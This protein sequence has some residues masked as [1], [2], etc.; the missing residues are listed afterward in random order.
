[1]TTTWSAPYV[2]LGDPGKITLKSSEDPSFSL[3]NTT[4]GA[5]GLGLV[6]GNEYVTASVGWKIPAGLMRYFVPAVKRECESLRGYVDSCDSSQLSLVVDSS[7]SPPCPPNSQYGCDG[8]TTI[9]GDGSADFRLPTTPSITIA[10]R[11]S[12]KVALGIQNVQMPESAQA[13]LEALLAHPPDFASLANLGTPGQ[14][15]TQTLLGL[16]GTNGKSTPYT[17]LTCDQTIVVNAAD[18]KPMTRTQAL[19]IAGTRCGK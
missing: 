13:E 15:S 6:A 9:P 3:T 2:T 7:A 19:E 5:R 16:Y 1:M 12:G 14:S 10:P 11:N 4:V 8:L 17:G 18:S